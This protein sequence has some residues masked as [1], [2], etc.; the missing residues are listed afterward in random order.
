MLAVHKKI[1]PAR[2]RFGT[3]SLCNT[4]QKVLDKTLLGCEEVVCFLD[5]ELI[6]DQ[7]LKN[8]KDVFKRLLLG[9][10]R[11]RV[12]INDSPMLGR[13]FTLSTDHKSVTIFGSDK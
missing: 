1:A 5:D 10:F 9:G 11:L 7:H 4:F 8:F 2:L 13:K 12:V 6:I 3:K